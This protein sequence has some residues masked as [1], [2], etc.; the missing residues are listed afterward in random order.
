M[1]QYVSKFLLIASLAVFTG[2][3][4]P[5]QQQYTKDEVVAQIL[6][7]SL[8]K[9]HYSPIEVNDDMSKRTFSLL[10]KRM[11]YNKNFLL[12][13]DVE[14]LRQYEAQIDD[15]LRRGSNELFVLSNT[16]LQQRIQEAQKYTEEILSHPFD[17][18]KEEFIELDPE[19][20]DFA[21]NE[22]ELKDLWRRMLKYQTL[23]RYIDMVESRDKGKDDQKGDGAVAKTDAE[24]EAEAREKILKNQNQR[25]E[26]LLKENDMDRIG[27]YLGAVSLSFEPH[28][29]YFPPDDKENF[30]IAM[31]GSLEGI[32]A[33]L[34]ESDGYIKVES[35]V[36]GSASWKQK[37]LKPED[38][39]LKVAQGDTEPVDVVDMRLDDAVKL[40]R[41]KKG[42]EVRLTVKKP[43]GRITV[44]PIIRDVVVLEE[45][46]AKSAV[47]KDESSDKRFG[48]VYLPKFYADFNKSG[49]RS[50]AD[51]IRKELEKLRTE[52]VD[53]IVLDLRNNGGGSLQDAV[54]MTGHFIP[55]GPV[56]QVRNSAGDTEVLSD[57]DPAVT[58]DGPLV[59]L[60]NNYSAS[61]S[62]ILA[63]AL[64]DYGRAVIV[65]SPTTFGKGTVQTF[66]DLDNYLNPQ[67]AALKPLGSLKITFQKFYRINGGST[68]FKGVT[69]DIILPDSY[70]MLDIGE[71]KLE[72]AL[73]WDTIPAQDYKPWGSELHYSDL[74]RKSAARIAAN[75]SFRLIEENAQ[76]MKERRDDTKQP[77]NIDKVRSEQ[78]ELK[79]ESKKFEDAQQEQPHI[80]VASPSADKSKESE[81]VMKERIDEWHQQ[82]KKDV[83]IAEAMAILKD[84]IQK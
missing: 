72:Y 40:I 19:K 46:Y 37:E 27:R 21:K 47:I 42:T 70:S 24:L 28:T 50:S 11:D 74:R 77:L 26:R 39:I 67:F 84:M 49:G 60:V 23:M 9:G 51:D 68:Q 81:A 7:N 1:K 45:T 69:P 25:F 75:E 31:S 3:S 17:F 78:E 29:E 48:Y 71:K 53:G 16:M 32:G 15:E 2:D 58:Y 41:G 6:L 64:Q 34:R 59:V 66:I 79:A 52:K 83:T 38:I 62:E 65:G 73:P 43:D 36:P 54:R 4:L 57:T 55:T 10:L 30:D 61:A 12:R 44:I 13:K 20:R 22:A 14:Q 33:Q 76:R 18:S 5:A 82:I 56:V 8:E 80:R 63:A 35:I